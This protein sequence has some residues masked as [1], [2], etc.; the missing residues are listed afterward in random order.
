MALLFFG[1]SC[2]AVAVL[3][4]SFRETFADIE[5]RMEARVRGKG[6][7]GTDRDYNRT[8]GKRGRVSLSQR[9]ELACAIFGIVWLLP[10][11]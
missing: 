1:M 5:S 10:I 6:D 8:T 7:D 3:S 11:R 9:S 4:N 2:N